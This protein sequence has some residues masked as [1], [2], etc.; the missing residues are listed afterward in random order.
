[1]LDVNATGTFLCCQAFGREMVERGAGRI[2]NVASVAGL[3][4]QAPAVLDA[5]GYSASKGAVVALTRDL[6]AKWAPR[7]VIVNAV[8]PGFFPTRMTQAHIDKNEPALVA[9]T[10]M[11]RLGRAGE[12][13]GVVLFLASEAASYVTGQVLAVD[14]GMT[15]W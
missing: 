5:V 3:V 6:A 13:K 4:G 15:T 14:G 2:V 8:A 11:G 9:A 12:L 7:G 1:V 10:P